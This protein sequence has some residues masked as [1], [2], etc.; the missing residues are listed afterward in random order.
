MKQPIKEEQSAPVIPEEVLRAVKQR[1][2]LY[3]NVRA[4]SE[5]DPLQVY[6]LSTIEHNVRFLMEAGDTDLVVRV[7]TGEITFVQECNRLLQFNSDPLQENIFSRTK[8]RVKKVEH[9]QESYDSAMATLVHVVNSMSLSMRVDSPYWAAL[10]RRPISDSERALLKQEELSTFRRQLPLI[11]ATRAMFCYGTMGLG[12]VFD[13]GF[14]GLSPFKG[15][16]IDYAARH[17][18]T[19]ASAADKFL[20]ALYSP[21]SY[22]P[23]LVPVCAPPLSPQ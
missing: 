21:A 4:I 8:S 6:A 22:H 23:E 16:R 13:L 7:I 3:E 14:Y 10:K 12:N 1:R 9:D 11:E 15:D 19:K 20:R 5:G 18:H 2:Q 17:L